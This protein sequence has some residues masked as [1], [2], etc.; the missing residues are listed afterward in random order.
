[1]FFLSPRKIDNEVDKDHLSNLDGEVFTL[2]KE[3]TNIL[4]DLHGGYFCCFSAFSFSS[5]VPKLLSPIGSCC[6]LALTIVVN[7]KLSVMTMN[8]C[9]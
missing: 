1:M 5:F 9:I 3:S 6:K 4:Q 7:N 8:L 2:L